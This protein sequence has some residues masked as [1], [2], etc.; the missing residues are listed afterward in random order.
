MI[1]RL[2]HKLKQKWLRF[3]SP[4]MIH[5]YFDHDGV[6]L[7]GVRVSNSTFIDYPEFL[8][9][10]ENVFIGHFNFIEA[11]NGISIG[12]GCQ[13]TNFVSITSH[14]SHKSIRLYGREYKGVDMKAYV[15]APVEIGAFSFIGP[16]STIMPG[17]SIGKGCIVSANSYV[18]GNF[19]DFSIIAGNPAKSVG[20]SREMD[21]PYLNE[22]PEL[23]T[24]YD[25]WATKK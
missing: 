18:N 22:F 20:D 19:P 14:S 6:L 25:D 9:L 15:K 11:S 12:E 5:P 24:F 13:I 10:G 4:V 7:K 8:K 23:R 1:I 3:G 17:S 21:A 16:H 2:Y